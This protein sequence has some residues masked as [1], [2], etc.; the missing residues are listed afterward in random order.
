MKITAP[1]TPPSNYRSYTLNTNEDAKQ[2]VKQ[3]PPQ[4]KIPL[5]N[6]IVIVFGTHIST[7][8]SRA[9]PPVGP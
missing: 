2:E 3:F 1:F 5:S 4:K 7:A 8:G 9:S 6:N